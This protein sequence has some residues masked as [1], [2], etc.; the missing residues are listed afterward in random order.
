ML[1]STSPFSFLFKAS[2]M[3]P[4]TTL[5]K[6]PG[7][8]WMFLLSLISNVTTYVR[9]KDRTSSE[10]PNSNDSMARLP[11]WELLD[12]ILSKILKMIGSMYSKMNSSWNF[13]ETLRSLIKAPKRAGVL[14]LSK[15]FNRNPMIKG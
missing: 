6:N 13:N 11:E 7:S 1:P 9:N 2:G 10:V 15:P 8:L 4:E 5:E 3:T 12:S 14:N